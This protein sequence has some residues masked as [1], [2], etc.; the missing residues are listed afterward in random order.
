VS[1]LKIQNVLG[2]ESFEYNPGT[3]TVVEGKNGHGKTSILEAI[4]AAIGGGRCADLVREGADFG[5][6][7]LMLDN[8]VEITRKIKTEG[9][10]EPE[11]RLPGVGPI[12][13]PQEYLNKLADALSVNPVAFLTA[14][15]A[16]RTS[17]MLSSMVLRVTAAQIAECGI[18]V[19]PEIEK[20]IP[21]K[22]ALEIC[23][24]LEKR[25]TTERRDIG[26]DGRKAAAAAD[27]LAQT[28]PPD[29]EQE[30]EKILAQKRELRDQLER[31]IV[32]IQTTARATAE[33]ERVDARRQLD[34]AVAEAVARY[35]RAVEAA[36]VERDG[37]L[38]GFNQLYNEELERISKATEYSIQAQANLHLAERDR[39]TGEVSQA[40]ERAKQKI[41]NDMIREDVAKNREEA[42]IANERYDRY[43]GKLEN[44]ATLRRNLLSCLPIAG[45]EIKD[46][47]I[48]VD[49]HPFD[50]VNHARKVTVAVELA[51]L[52]SAELGLI[53]V[54]GLESLDAETFAA[55]ESTIESYGL[56]LIGARVTNEPLHVVSRE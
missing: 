7:Y 6:I 12:R 32:Q 3:I 10:S 4:R 39:L 43:S 50:R 26:R 20:Q 13:R 37:L 46:G 15:P 48:F 14:S 41:R 42:R 27:R 17:I 22:H 21:H 23:D 55:F 33:A 2:I 45:V 9:A 35:E 34:E 44:L 36:R 47:E 56:Q 16:E 11:V 29:D 52:R 24:A 54:D 28:L 51:L 19:T 5:Q 18:E 30:W 8:G 31:T 40:E 1:H 25:L 38:A 49:G 53:C